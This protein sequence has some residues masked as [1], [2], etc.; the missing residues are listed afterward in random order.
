MPPTDPTRADTD[1]DGLGDGDEVDLGTDPTK[2]DTDSDHDGVRDG[3]EVSAAFDPLAFNVT[4]IAS[5]SSQ[6]VPANGRAGEARLS[7]DGR[8][9]VFGS[10]ASN[11]VAGD[12]NART[13][14]FRR[15][16]QTGA[17][18]RVSLTSGGAQIGDADSNT[19][20]ISADGGD[21][22]FRSLSS[23]VVAGD[24]NGRLDIFARDIDQQT[25]TRVSVASNGTEGNGNSSTPIRSANGRYV[26]FQSE[27]SNLVAGDTNAAS[28]IFVRDTIAGTTTRASVTAAAT[29]NE[30]VGASVKPAMSAD[31]RYVAFESA[32]ALTPVQAGNFTGVFLRKIN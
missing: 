5:V 23:S 6:A 26:A 30:V 21:V 17:T 11:L 1:S 3:A 32:G 19:P 15:D 31:G 20:T 8:Y 16:T 18:I 14:I 27:A 28:D 24:T 4:S 13:D 12:T 10:A 9:V 25:T 2:A 7:A 29:N 22:A